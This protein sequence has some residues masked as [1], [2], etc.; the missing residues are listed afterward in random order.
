[1]IQEA[2]LSRK[3]EDTLRNKIKNIVTKANNQSDKID[4]TSPHTSMASELLSSS[5]SS[6]MKSD[7]CIKKRNVLSYI[8]FIYLSSRCDQHHNQIQIRNHQN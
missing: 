7:V 3:D 1:M 6:R 5:S 2:P 4:S 8:H